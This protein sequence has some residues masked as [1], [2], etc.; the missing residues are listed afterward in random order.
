MNSCVP[1]LVY[2]N[3]LLILVRDAAGC[4]QVWDS[5]V[6]VGT[7]SVFPSF[8]DFAPVSRSQAV[9]QFGGLV[10]FAKNCCFLVK[11]LLAWF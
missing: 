2:S 11:T 8:P 7:S 5:D 1:N 3:S 9:F 10:A 4:K 6:Q